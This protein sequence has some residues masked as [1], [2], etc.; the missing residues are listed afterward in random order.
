M[1]VSNQFFLKDNNFHET[2]IK[3]FHTFKEGNDFTSEDGQEMK[4]HKIVLSASSFFFTRLGAKMKTK[5]LLH[6]CSLCGKEGKIH[7]I[8]L[9][10]EANHIESMYNPCDQ[11][12]RTMKTR[13]A[14]RQH[15]YKFHNTLPGSD[16]ANS[17]IM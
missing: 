17:P 11:C 5:F 3:A 2:I 10:I 7:N 15:K 12:D 13:D 1:G 4:F 6:A 9:P 14:L 8:K 16:G